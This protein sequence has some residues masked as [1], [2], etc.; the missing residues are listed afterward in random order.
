M[1]ISQIAPITSEKKIEL[2]EMRRLYEDEL[3]SL[4]EIGR[5]FGVTRQAVQSRFVTAGIPRRSHY[6]IRF[7]EFTE[8]RRERAIQLLT[9][10]SD[11]IVRMYADEELTLAKIGKS[12]DISETRIRDHLVECGVEIRSAGTFRKFPQLGELKVGESILLPKPKSKRS[13]YFS[14]YRMARLFKIRISLKSIDE[15]NFRATRIK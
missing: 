6:S 14:F 11:D 1:P 7:I 2:E 13:L 12:L 5:V 15:R 4:R 3:M 10:N 9:A 8:Q